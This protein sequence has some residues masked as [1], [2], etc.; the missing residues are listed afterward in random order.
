MSLEKNMS[1][2]S[3]RISFNEYDA[4]HV[5][6]WVRLYWED[7]FLRHPDFKKGVDRF[8]NCPQCRQIGKRLEKFIGKKEVRFVEGLVKAYRKEILRKKLTQK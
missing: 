7:D 6:E 5:Y 3:K 1:K 2:K 8:G 4:V